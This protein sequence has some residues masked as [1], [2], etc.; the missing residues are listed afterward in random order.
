MTLS[1]GTTELSIF[2]GRGD[3]WKCQRGSE[4]RGGS[5]FREQ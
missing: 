4:L 5:Q 3:L 1:S 2:E